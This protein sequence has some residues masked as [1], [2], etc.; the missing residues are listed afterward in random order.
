MSSAK[1]DEENP[2]A[3]LAQETS[4]KE[5]SHFTW[6]CCG[7]GLLVC[8]ADTDAGCLMVAAQSGANWAYSLLLLQILLIPVLFF[9]QELTVRLGVYTGMG[10][11]AC[12]KR[13]FGSGWAWFTTI[14]LVMECVLST[15]SEMSGI[16]AV[17]ELWGLGRIGGTLVAAV[18]IVGIVMCCKYRQIEF[19]GITLG[20]FEL[21][22]VITMFCFH[23]PLME[24]FWGM[25][26]FHFDDSEYLTLYAANIG[27]VVM[28][29]MIYFQQSAVVARR[30]TTKDVSE[31]GAQTLFGCCLT[32]LV[33]IGT[34]ITYAA[35]RAKSVD[36]I[37]DMHLAL[38][39]V[40]GTLPSK[41]MISLALVGGSLCAAFVVSLAA[42]WAICETTGWDDIQAVDQGPT[43]A[44]RFYGVF[45]FII[46]IGCIVLTSGVHLVNLNIFI[47]LINGLLMPVV[48]CF[49]FLLACSDLLPLHARLTGKYKVLLGC[50]FTIC[51]STS[52]I[53]G[54]TGLVRAPPY[55]HYAN[56]FLE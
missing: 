33:M 13:R 2:E 56:S 14:L 18:T 48:I 54:I 50:L 25:F 6:R 12:I 42:A 36:S 9:A 55:G 8:L 21:T 27:A 29:F 22:F 34:V 24:V 35:S 30:L 26:T 52:L 32:Q 3:S 41:I 39:P 15:I 1:K 10:H 23:P 16:A 45:L 47:E 11:A 5:S 46:G 38:E 37:L 53:A 51:A 17:M 31:E 19:I 43:E 40:L 49:L 4:K 28:P 20:L 7:P 44:P